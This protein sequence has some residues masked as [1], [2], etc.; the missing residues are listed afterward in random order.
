MRKSDEIISELGLLALVVILIF[1]E[2]LLWGQALYLSGTC[3][4]SCNSNLTSKETDL[5]EIRKLH[6]T[7]L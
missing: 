1:M 4:M 6:I 5:A 2:H 7:C 3:L